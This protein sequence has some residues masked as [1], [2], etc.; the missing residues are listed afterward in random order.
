[1]YIT[2]DT[3]EVVVLVP[4]LAVQLVLALYT[5]ILPSY[6]IAMSS[7]NKGTCTLNKYGNVI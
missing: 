5:C 2:F 3:P 1:M 6:V 4:F 7:L